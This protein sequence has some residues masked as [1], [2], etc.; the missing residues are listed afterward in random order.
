MSKPFA[1]LSV[2]IVGAGPAGFYTAQAL[3]DLAP[4]A[5]IDII[6]RLPTPFG[7]IRYGVAPDHQET[8]K[9]QELFESIALL[10]QI[11]FVGNIEIGKDI[12]LAELRECYDAVVL[13][14]GVPHDAELGIPGET[15]SGV[16]GAARF[17]GWYNGHPDQA[18]LRPRLG[19]PGVIVIGNGNVAIDIARLL[20]KSQAELEHSDIAP[21]ALEQIGRA[22]PGDVHIVGRRGPAQAKFTTDELT[23]LGRLEQAVAVVDAED[24]PARLDDG[25]SMKDKRIKTRNL[26]CFR[27]YAQSDPAG[28]SRRIHFRFYLRPHAIL[29]NDCV[30]GVRFERVAVSDG[31]SAGTG[32]MLDIPCSTVISAIGYRACALNGV[33]LAVAGNCLRNDE[34]RIDSGLYVVGW[35]RR[36]PS[37]KI[38]TN[39]ADGESVAQRIQQE[40]EPGRLAGR[41][42]L[43]RLVRARNLSPVDFPGWK[44]IET[45][46]R[47]N[48]PTAAVRRKMTRISEMLD[49]S[50]AL[51]T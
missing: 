24:I 8:K 5:R 47:A 21:Y 42:G 31:G 16:Y 18:D 1:S 17:V 36:G 10:P 15:L 43:E 12:T 35:L 2:A 19:K 51:P 39:R 13:A 38:G 29:G 41:A 40:V 11:D 26:E 45:F 4:D 3:A 50:R 33:E 20:S 9:I 37:G 14:Y 49:V 27:A 48:A 34:G 23:E 7:L 6:D 28:R 22:A 30:E 25:L 46:E 32:E 44:R